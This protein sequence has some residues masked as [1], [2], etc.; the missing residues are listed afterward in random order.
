MTLETK[1]AEL[2]T[3]YPTIRFGSD[4][5]GYVALDSVEYEAT[6]TKWA[7]SALDE[8]TAQSVEAS[9]QAKAIQDRA[10]GITKAQTLG[11]TLAQA[12]LMFP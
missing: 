7:Q 2:K 4:E 12:E 10:T 6:I 3:Q 5:E 11:F 8:Q 1:I 9:A